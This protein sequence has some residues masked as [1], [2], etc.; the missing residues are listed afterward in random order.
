MVPC[1]VTVHGA[2]PVNV[3]DDVLV[4]RGVMSFRA[5]SPA[6]FITIMV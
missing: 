5:F 2:F 6:G 4:V 1:A 3:Y